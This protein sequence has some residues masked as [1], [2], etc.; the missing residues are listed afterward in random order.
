MLDTSTR[1]Q[2]C[3]IG[4]CFAIDGSNS[5]SERD[6]ERQNFLVRKITRNVPNSSAR[7]A[8]MQYGRSSLTISELTADGSFVRRETRGT[9]QLLSGSTFLSAGLNFCFSELFDIVRKRPVC[10]R[11]FIVLMGNGNDDIGANPVERARLFES[12]V[13]GGEVVAVRFGLGANVSLLEA[14]SGREN[15]FDAT[16][17][18]IPDLA[19]EIVK[20]LDI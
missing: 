12:E 8:A 13:E 4:I 19:T 10:S 16:R 11:S 7:F 14:I 3:S 18:S 1:Q 15:F 17:S 9:Q 2:R 6:F 5:I 20:S